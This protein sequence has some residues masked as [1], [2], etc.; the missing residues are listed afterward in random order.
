MKE[1]ESSVFPILSLRFYG[2]IDSGYAYCGTG[3]GGTSVGA[4]STEVK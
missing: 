3:P 1:V 4:I 2:T